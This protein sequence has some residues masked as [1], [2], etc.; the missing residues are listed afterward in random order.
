[1]HAK[2]TRSSRNGNKDMEKKRW[3]QHSPSIFCPLLQER[4]RHLSP[5]CGKIKIGD[6]S[7]LSC[8]ESQTPYKRHNRTCCSSLR[9]ETTVKIKQMQLQNPPLQRKATSLEGFCN[10]EETVIPQRTIT[11][12]QSSHRTFNGKRTHALQQHR[13][14]PC[15]GMYLHNCHSKTG[16]GGG[17]EEGR[18]RGVRVRFRDRFRGKSE[19]AGVRVRIRV[20]DMRLALALQ[21]ERIFQPMTATRNNQTPAFPFR[22]ALEGT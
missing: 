6:V 18:S 20:R 16:W 4:C 15:H 22:G 7:C 11:D 5:A 3:F 12:N 17:E 1:M 2:H 9:S 8:C 21:K 13:Q 14:E 10:R 19:G